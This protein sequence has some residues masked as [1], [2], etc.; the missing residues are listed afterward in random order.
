[1]VG[2]GTGVPVGG[3]GVAEGGA[4]VLLGTGVAGGIVGVDTSA[5]A[6]TGIVG[7]GGLA[8]EAGACAGPTTGLIPIYAADSTR[9][10]A[11]TMANNRQP[12]PLA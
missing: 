9:Q 2:V 12:S 8:G 5:F 7:V 4:G 6:T 3:R 1:M 10:P 11:K